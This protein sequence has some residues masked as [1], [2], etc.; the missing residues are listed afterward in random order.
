M[1]RLRATIRFDA[2]AHCAR[3]FEAWRHDE[4]PAGEAEAALFA[5]YDH[6]ARLLGLSRTDLVGPPR[7]IWLGDQLA[8]E[9]DRSRQAQ[10]VRLGAFTT[11]LVNGKPAGVP[12]PWP[13][14]M[15]WS[16]G[17]VQRDVAFAPGV[18]EALVF[19]ADSGACLGRVAPDQDRLE[20]PAERLVVLSQSD[21]ST[22]SFGDAI[23]A[24]DPRFK[25]AW[26]N[27][28]EMVAFFD[29]P[30]LLLATPQE[31]AVWI[32]SS[33][34]GRDGARALYACD[35][36]LQLRINPDIGGASRIVRARVGESVRF[37]S[38]EVD[39]EGAASL[40][41]SMLGFTQPGNPAEVIF[42][43]LAP[44]AEGDGQA[45]AELSTR[46][47]IWPG[48]PAPDEDLA[49]AA[50]PGNF[51]EARSAGLKVEGRRSS[52]AGE[53]RRK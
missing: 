2:S 6:A 1:T 38:L 4:Q 36:S 17:V 10:F 40:D 39:T 52:G 32:S 28:G 46:A 33:V 11:K 21:F 27:P 5:A 19:D 51:N 45:R 50:V 29:R 12:A 23:P 24:K 25:L 13:E 16:A 30:N 8:L 53:R 35:G 3:R 14:Q 7:V 20:V 34:L 37:A 43:L 44:G 48:V 42:D 26:V 18:G 41:F 47:W 31:G 9:A 49:A 15:N 22:P